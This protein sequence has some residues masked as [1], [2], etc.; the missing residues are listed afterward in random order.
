MKRIMSPMTTTM[1]FSTTIRCTG[2]PYLQMSMAPPSQVLVLFQRL[3]Q[4]T[5]KTDNIKSF[6]DYEWSIWV[7]NNFY[8]VLTTVCLT[9][10][11]ERIP[12]SS[13]VKYALIPFESV[14]SD[15]CFVNDSATPLTC[16]F[17]R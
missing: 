14:L 17:K 12:A 6:C 1:Q 3:T 4:S 10:S 2:F 13:S 8:Y 9:F 16:T 7:Q 5:E 15:A 11:N